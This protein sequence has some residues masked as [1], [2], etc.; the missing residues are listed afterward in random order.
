MTGALVVPLAHTVNKPSAGTL[1]KHE[2]TWHV[3]RIL[4]QSYRR[5]VAALS[6]HG[7]TQVQPCVD[8]QYTHTNKLSLQVTRHMPEESE[9]RGARIRGLAYWMYCWG[10]VMLLYVKG[11]RKHSQLFLCS[12]SAGKENR[13]AAI[14]LIARQTSLPPRS[15]TVC[16]V[17]Q[18]QSMGN[19]V[20]QLRYQVVIV[21]VW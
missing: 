12:R 2:R 11:G 20:S 6:R 14:D 10:S 16:I 9:H 13:W 17:C 15:A 5:T 1:I 8:T 19:S 7:H 4:Q 3:S 18:R 21:F